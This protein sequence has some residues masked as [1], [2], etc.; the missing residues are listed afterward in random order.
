MC[1]KKR[2]SEKNPHAGVKFMLFLRPVNEIG[3]INAE[4]RQKICA[5]DRWIFRYGP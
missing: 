2:I 3:Y 4:E 1:S 5:G